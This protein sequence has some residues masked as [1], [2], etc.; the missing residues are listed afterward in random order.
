M[1]E[2]EE[3]KWNAAVDA[4]TCSSCDRSV[5]EEPNEFCPVAHHWRGY[6]KRW[7]T[8]F[9]KKDIELQGMFQLQSEGFKEGRRDGRRLE[10]MET[11]GELLRLEDMVRLGGFRSS[12]DV[13]YKTAF[14]KILEWVK[15]R[16][17]TAKGMK[18]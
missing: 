16:V 7:F 14:E 1:N 8:G 9:S 2:D 6:H 11:F 13:G 4:E 12:D 17:R 15:V 10:R 18:E 3:K 5:F